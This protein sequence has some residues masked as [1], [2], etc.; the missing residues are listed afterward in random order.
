MK[1][2]VRVFGELA[3]IIG[4]RHVQELG[5]GATIMTLTGKLAKKAGLKRHGYLGSYKVGGGDLAI[6]VNGH[7]IELLD[8]VKTALRDGD[9]VVLLI[10]TSGG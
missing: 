9:E 8:G 4:N 7:N 6:L 3:P 5:E 1:V 2:T 10:P